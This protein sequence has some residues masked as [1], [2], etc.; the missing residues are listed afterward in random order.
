M[1]KSE[2]LTGYSERFHGNIEW[3]LS[4][5]LA[6][7]FASFVFIESSSHIQ[8]ELLKVV[9][10]CLLLF[11]IPFHIFGLV[12]CRDAKHVKSRERA[13]RFLGVYFGV[14]L[15][16]TSVGFWRLFHLLIIYM[17]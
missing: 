11:A 8:N 12:S 5:L 13:D 6:V 14:G 3:V 15:L 2:S 10:S 1:K 17:E 7:S 9:A 16:G 4:S